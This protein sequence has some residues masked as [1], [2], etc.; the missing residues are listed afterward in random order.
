MTNA[1]KPPVAEPVL[2]RLATV[3]H[4]RPTAGDEREVAVIAPAD[5]RAVLERPTRARSYEKRAN[6]R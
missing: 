2:I 3:R 6:G 4:T 5:E 1:F